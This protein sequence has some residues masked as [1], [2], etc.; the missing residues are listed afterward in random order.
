M[1]LKKY[2]A[3][4]LLILGCHSQNEHETS[5]II[6]VKDYAKDIKIPRNLYLELEKEIAAEFKNISPVFVYLPLQVEFRQKG[7]K[8]LKDSPLKFVFEKGGGQIDLK[9][10]IIGLGTFYLSFP[11]EQ[12]SKDLE[13]MHLYYISQAPVKKIDDESFGLGCGKWID[14][15][16]RFVKMQNPEFLKLN[17]T[18]KRHL[19]VLAGHY[20]FV[21]KQANEIYLTQL[22]L[23]DSRYSQE[24]CTTF[25]PGENQ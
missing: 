15:K 17:T 21:F 18:S 22:T 10:V 5:N 12:F 20:V 14:L 24:L 8:V 3:F 13:L 25:S 19:F 23:S 16:S 2:L 7:Q 6:K 9:D 4:F 1:N 11:S